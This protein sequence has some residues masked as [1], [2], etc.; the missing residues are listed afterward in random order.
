MT[1]KTIHKRRIAVKH[2]RGGMW[3]KAIEF[4]EAQLPNA[5]EKR[6]DQIRSA[7]HTFR[8]NLERGVPWPGTSATQN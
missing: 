8:A 6:A 7:I 1:T 5:N 3:K 4:L 2:K